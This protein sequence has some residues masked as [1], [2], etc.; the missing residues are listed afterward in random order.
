MYQIALLCLLLFPQKPQ[1]TVC[2][3]FG[4]EGEKIHMACRGVSDFVIPRSEWPEGWGEPRNQR[5]F[6][7]ELVGRGVDILFTPERE[8]IRN[9]ELRRW[10]RKAIE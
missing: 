4:I 10:R 7:A 3:I 2:S 5:K 9:N 8:D 6:D 1:P